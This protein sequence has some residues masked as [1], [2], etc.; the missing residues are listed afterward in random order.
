MYFVGAQRMEDSLSNFWIVLTRPI[1]KWDNIP[2]TDSLGLVLPLKH[3]T[4][5]YIHWPVGLVHWE[6]NTDPVRSKY[7][8]EIKFSDWL[9]KK[10]NRYIVQNFLVKET[11]INVEKYKR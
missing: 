7:W 5:I 11:K 8:V 6:W 4:S 2:I 9:I 10:R 1:S 3:K